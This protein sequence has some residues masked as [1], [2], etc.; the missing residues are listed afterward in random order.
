MHL[1]DIEYMV[2]IAETKSFTRAAQQ[3]YVSQSALSQAIQRLEEELNVKL[4]NREPSVITLTYAGQVFYN[5]SLEILNACHRIQAKMS[6]ISNLKAGILRIAI[7]QNYS[8]LYIATVI[9]AYRKLY[10]GIELRLSETISS[11]IE[12]YCR[13]GKADLGVLS[14]PLGIGNL[15]YV[16]LFDEAVY[17]CLPADHPVALSYRPDEESPLIDLALVKDDQFILLKAG[18]RLREQA[19]QLCQAAGFQPGIVFETSSVATTLEFVR[20]DLGIGFITELIRKHN[21]ENGVRYFKILYNGKPFSRTF[22]AI[23]S[24][25]AY[26]SRAAAEFIRLAGEMPLF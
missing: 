19:L 1:R 13:K 24:E 4:F 2:C 25:N 21:N 20:N 8:S 23:Y 5:D 22:A 6:D 18:Q 14:L 26:L 16:P 11:N 9:P 7:P 10:P 17:L 3:L 12:E 15:K